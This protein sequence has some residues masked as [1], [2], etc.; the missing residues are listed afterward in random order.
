[1]S[2]IDT[3]RTSEPADRLVFPHRL[4]PYLKDKLQGRD[5]NDPLVKQYMPH[6]AESDIAPEEKADPIGDQAH[7]PVKGIVHR[8]ADRV[9]L[10]IVSVCAVYCRYCFRRDMIGPGHRGLS[11][12]EL[13][14]ALTYIE[15]HP[16]IREV[17]LTGGD[18]L[19]LS[20]EKL[21]RVLFRLDQIPRL[22]DIRIHTRVPVAD[23][24][25]VNDDLVRALSLRKPLYMCLH[26]NH[27]VD[28]MP[29]VEKAIARLRDADVILLSQSVLLKGVN[30]NA[31][32]LTELCR[33][34]T[35]LGIVPYY[36][37]HPDLAPGTRHFR[38]PLRRGIALMREVRSRLPGFACPAYMIDI[39][40][41]YGKVP[42]D[43]GHVED[44][45]DGTYEIRDYAGTTHIYKDSCDA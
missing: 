42:A 39:P 1:M 31:A 22:N 17:I 9:L 12:S 4:T 35:A 3:Q 26:I 37:H 25:R 10:K 27:A 19:V 15:R 7:S 24:V 43:S 6:P 13:Q 16:D 34:L 45:H 11:E 36:I 14:T 32:D 18:P 44:R 8:H 28:L 20:P 41:G 23:P 29:E 30:D 21:R 2:A 38:L 5:E 33:R 40:G